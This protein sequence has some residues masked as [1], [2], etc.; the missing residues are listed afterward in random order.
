[1]N[2]K[3]DTIKTLEQ[4]KDKLSESIVKLKNN[5]EQ[6]KQES[7]NRNVYTIT[8]YNNSFDNSIVVEKDTP[9]HTTKKVG[10]LQEDLGITNHSNNSINS[11]GE[12]DSSQILNNTSIQHQNQ[13]IDD[14][15]K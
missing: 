9:T 1:M 10:N 8:G 15:L 11:F 7:R 6:I 5:I 13:F 4:E 14:S 2:D 12:K 3:N